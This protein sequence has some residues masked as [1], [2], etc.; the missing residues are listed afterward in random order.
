MKILYA[1]GELQQDVS[2]IA[3][4]LLVVFTQEEAELQETFIRGLMPLVT[5]EFRA[6]LQQVLQYTI[7]TCDT[8]SS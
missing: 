6:H 4:D 8:L 2:L 3:G 5:D 7:T 1:T